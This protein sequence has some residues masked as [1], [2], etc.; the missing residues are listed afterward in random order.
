MT[1]WKHHPPSL[2][3]FEQVEEVFPSASWQYVL[4]GM[5]FKTEPRVTERRYVDDK[6]AQQFYA[7]NVKVTNQYFGA[8][9][10]NRDL[11][12]KILQ[13]GMQKI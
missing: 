13:Y 2:H 4:Y 1:L 8:L 5:G 7:E 9:Q 12:N 6:K 11:I 10:T 3:D